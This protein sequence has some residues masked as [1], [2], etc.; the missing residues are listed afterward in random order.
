M[1]I[2]GRPVRTTI[3]FGLLAGIAFVP[4]T[5]ILSPILFW[6][7]AFKLTIWFYLAVYGVLLTRWGRANPAAVFFPTLL[8]LLFALLGGWSPAAYLLFA[9]GIMS[10]IRSGI[11][12]QGN[13]IRILGTEIVISLGGAALVAFFAPN[14]TVAWALGI[15]MFFLVQ[16]LYFVF[17]GISDEVAGDEM[18][19]DRFEQAR[20]QVEK[21]L[22]NAVQ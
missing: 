15:W 19:M 1:K 18:S 5:M 17:M 3:I 22:S 11:C 16:S 13:F 10:W 14:S 21:I 2:T 6:P 8:L 20:R 7:T 9:V 4:L 12:F